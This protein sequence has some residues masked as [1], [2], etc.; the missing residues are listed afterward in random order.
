MIARAVL[1]PPAG[2]AMANEV[3][4]CCTI[5]DECRGEGAIAVD[6]PL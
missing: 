6:N 4:G 2:D 3:K 1:G 5:L